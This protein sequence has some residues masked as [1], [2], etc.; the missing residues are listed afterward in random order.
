[1]RIAQVVLPHASAYERKSQRIDRAALSGTHEVVALPLA[2]VRNSGAEVAHLY[3]GEELP[4]SELVGFPVPYLANAPLKQARWSWR[5]PVPPARVVTPLDLPEAVEDA[6]FE[7]AGD[8]PGRN[9]IGTFA[10]PAVRDMIERTLARIHRFRDD[11]TWHL[12]ER[13]PTPV[14]LAAV[15]IWVDP[16][17]SEPDHD[18]FVAEALVAG[19][20]VVAARTA[21]NAARLEKGRTGWLVPVNDPNEMTHAILSALFKPEVASSKVSA[22]RQTASKFR[23]R[24]RLRV[25]VPLYE[26]LVK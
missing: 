24:H 10:R 14:D 7:A 21:V 12:F 13:T 20:P 22:A 16:A 18:G 1:M 5:K 3:A 26:A 4:H 23:A 9:I 19:L 6:Y 11:V 25:L 17:M 15:D 2:E 8:R